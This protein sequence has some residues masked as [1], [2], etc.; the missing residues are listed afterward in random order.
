MKQTLPDA[1]FGSFVHKIL[2]MTD[3]A[4]ICCGGDQ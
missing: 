3:G 4:R 2:C 1:A